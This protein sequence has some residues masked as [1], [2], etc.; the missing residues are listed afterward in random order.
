MRLPQQEGEEG[1]RGA[2]A[3]QGVFGQRVQIFLVVVSWGRREGGYWHLVVGGQ[4]CCQ[5][6]CNA[7]DSPRGE[8]LSPKCQ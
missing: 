4:G 6:S 5:T 7:E 1:K 2:F 3:A 8:E